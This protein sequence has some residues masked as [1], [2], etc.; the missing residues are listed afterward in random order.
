[1][2]CNLEQAL[3]KVEKLLKFS[4]IQKNIPFEIKRIEFEIKAMMAAKNK[5]LGGPEVLPYDSKLKETSKKV[6][7]EFDTLPKYVPGQKNM[8]YAGIGSRETPIEVLE[9]MTKASTWLGSKGYTLQSGGAIGADMAFEGKPYP[10]TL[11]AGSYDVVNKKGKVVLKAGQVV[12]I[13]SKEYTDAYYAFTDKSTKG[14]IVGSDWSEKVNVPNTKSFSSFDVV[15]NKFGNANKVKIIA[16]E[17]HP[18][19]DG[20]NQWVEALM[21]RNTYQIFGSNL[22][23]PVDFVLF[24]AKEGKGIR[25]EGGTGQAVEMARLKGIPTVNMADG[26][27]R[28]QLTAVLKGDKSTNKV[29]ANL[30]KEQT[31]QLNP[32]FKGKFILAHAGIGKSYA[33][34]YNSNL[35]DGDDLFT[36]AA[37]EVVT[38]YNKS[39]NE[40]VQT[41]PNVSKM[42]SIFTAW[43]E[44]STDIKKVQEA[45]KRREEVYQ[46]YADK[47]QQLMKQGKTILSSSARPATIKIA[48]YV[49]V[50]DNTELIKTNLQSDLR[51]NK[52]S[53]TD[54]N[55]IKEKINKFN[56]VALDN[57]IPL[58]KLSSQE[59]LSDILYSKDTTKSKP[60]DE[61]Y[62]KQTKQQEISTE[63]AS[64][65]NDKFVVSESITSLKG[66]QIFVFGA[67]AQGVHG[68][69]SALQARKFG[70]LNGEAVN[71]LSG[72]G[73]TWGIVTKESPYGSKVSRENLI[74]NT[75]KLLKYA[76]MP[77]NANKEF[78]FTAI[79]TG[80][81]GFTAEDVLEAIGDVNKYSNIKFP[82]QWKTIYENKEKETTED[83]DKYTVNGAELAIDE[84]LSTDS[85][86]EASTKY[87]NSIIQNN[88]PKT[89]HTEIRDDIKKCLLKIG[90]K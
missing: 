65:E 47:A 25:P 5:M 20:M 70:T 3:A 14:S 72:N 87:E 12:K 11:T 60:K 26:D 61:D 9:L 71:S 22:D 37:N 46:L 68:K 77:E 41:I 82:A 8:T 79:G 66:N 36:E 39:L 89:K 40:D 50:Q 38:K 1:M 24:Y 10:K 2:S 51:I 80:L 84:Y 86:P 78:L 4:A 90:S 30:V 44:Y 74:A 23:T 15:N 69:G 57:K 29:D 73:K 35:I 58:I 67:N 48:D 45:K 63:S 17:L 21:A 31:K 16:N 54:T 64:D 32:K 81:A 27:W 53:E 19:S 55:K 13:G 62:V 49:I 43:G 18:S 75:K 42:K 34:Q 7:P 83:L 56:Q 88:E 33:V 85:T 76:S 28:A 6:T 59:F 52:N